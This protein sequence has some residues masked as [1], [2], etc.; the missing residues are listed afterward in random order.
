MK[1]IYAA[2]LVFVVVLFAACSD[3]AGKAAAREA[4]LKAQGKTAA[5]NLKTIRDAALKYCAERKAPPEY[6]DQLAEFGA[7]SLVKDDNYSTEF[8][9]GFEGLKYADGKFSAG[10]FF[11]TPMEGKSAPDVAMSA[12]TGEVS[13]KFRPPPV[14]GEKS[15]ALSPNI[16]IVK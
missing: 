4:A 3:E 15:N 13:Y 7:G 6:M 12:E 10:R 1:S 5:A 8:G 9:Y 16:E 11:A 2:A 14:T